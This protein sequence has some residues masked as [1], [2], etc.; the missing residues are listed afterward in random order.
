MPRFTELLQSK[1]QPVDR[2]AFAGLLIL[3]ALLPFELTRPLLVLGPIS[4]SSVEVILYFAI[5]LWLITRLATRRT[6]WTHLHSA[7]AIWIAAMGLSALFAPTDRSDAIKFT[8][9]SLGGCLLFFATVDMSHTSRRI[10]AVMSAIAIGAVASALAGILEIQIPAASQFL[11]AFKTHISLIGGFMR[12]SGTFEYANIAGMYWEAALPVIV[13]SGCWWQLQR[14]QR[15]W[16]IIST[17]GSIVV[18]A[19]IVLSAS[20]AALAGSIVGTLIVIAFSRTP[21]SARSVRAPATLALT[22]L[23]GFAAI[24]F[25]SNPLFGLRL[26]SENNA[27]W[28]RADY[29]AIDLPATLTAGQRINVTVQITN[30]GIQP[31][32][33]TG[34]REVRLGYHWLDRAKENFIVFES[35]HHPLPRDLYPAEHDVI[36]LNVTAPTR[37]GDYFLQWDLVQEH[38]TW[39]SAIT[40]QFSGA[41]IQVVGRA[42]ANAPT[43]LEPQP[44][45]SINTTLPPRTDLWRAA[46]RMWLD[47]PLLGVGPDNFRRRYGP[48][49][50]MNP[51]NDTV[52]ANNL[53]LETLANLGLIGALAFG[54]FI[55]KLIA[56]ARKKWRSLSEPSAQVLAIGLSVAL[57]AFFI[58]GLVDTFL[59][60]TP[61]YGLFWLVCGLW[62]SVLN[63]DE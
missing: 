2:L 57:A 23:I 29:Q 63:E 10:T 4:L 43:P 13:I 46:I 19:A 11:S 17:L 22:T 44:V 3:A 37:S 12:A 25:A 35:M 26:Q 27:D 41:A 36:T 9:R 33:A 8:L 32:I 48:Y 16:L 39:F 58:H 34:E 45:S 60:F 5:A 30:T 7:A 55:F 53:Y 38:V 61:T 1:Y 15:R 54:W 56:I 59:A 18:I 40:R 49:L 47:Y 14:G 28:Y 31:W 52:N 50:G 24:S 20:R 51:F 42:P 6:H 62:V 21:R